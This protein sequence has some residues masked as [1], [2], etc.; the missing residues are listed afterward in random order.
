[1][2]VRLECRN[3]L[4]Y[5]LLRKK[6]NA[7]IETVFACPRSVK[8][9][10]ESFGIPHV[11]VGSVHVNGAA[12]DN[13]F[14]IR[15]DASVILKQ[16]DYAVDESGPPRFVLDCHLGTL[17]RYL[18]LLGFDSVYFKRID[19]A[20]LVEISQ[21]EGRVLMTR[22]T[23]LLMKKTVTSGMYVR[24]QEPLMQIR[25]TVGRFRLKHYI[26]PFSRCSICNTLLD[27]ITTEDDGFSH[28]SVM[29]PEKIRRF[30]SQFKVC[31]SCGKLYWNGSHTGNINEMIRFAL[32]E[33]C[34]L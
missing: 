20:D 24:S 30:Y 14:V 31:R 22:D 8:D 23:R 11:E 18:R 3:G 33:K 34:A 25:E 27:S 10:Y 21:S 7:V 6:V 9:L 5:F 13:S 12:V 16:C 1:M 17:A 15:T 29:L 19:D 26:S 2:K 28:F 32:S 4:E